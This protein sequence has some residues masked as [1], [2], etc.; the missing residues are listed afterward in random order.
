MIARDLLGCT[1]Q[2][3]FVAIFRQFS[4]IELFLLP[5]IIRASPLAS[6]AAG[7]QSHFSEI[8]PI[9]AAS[10]PYAHITNKDILITQTVER[11]TSR[12]IV[13]LIKK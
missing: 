5:N 1:E 10:N 3:R 12:S 2:V 9:L 4:D 13:H 8:V 11:V 6:N 7:F